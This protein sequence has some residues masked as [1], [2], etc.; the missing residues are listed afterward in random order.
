MFKTIAIKEWR[1]AW[2]NRTIV[3]G[4]LCL[5]LLLGIAFAGT[6]REASQLRVQRAAATALFRSQWEGMKAGNPHDAAHFGTYLFKP[7]PVLSGFDNGVNAVSGYSMRVEAH[8][9]HLLAAGPVGPADNYL[10]FGGLTMATVLG[11]FFPL[12]IILFCYATYTQERE[13]GTLK[14]LLL[15][16]ADQRRLLAGKTGFNLLVCNGLLLLGLLL[17]LPLLF[18]GTGL[19]AAGTDYIRAG[20]LVL[21][22]GSY[23]SILVLLC[24][25]FSAKLKRGTQVL[26]LL[27]ACWLFG[28]VLAP[29]VA[30]AAGGMLY[31]LP[32]RQVLQQK[33]DEAEKFGIH[34]DDPRSKRQ[35]RLQ[36]EWLQRYGVKTLAALPVNFDAIQMQAAEDYMQRI[37]DAEMGK[38]DRLIRAQN[39]IADQVA[40]LDPYLAL[41]SLSM[42]ICGSDYRHH[43]SFFRAAQQYRNDFIR[44]LN[45]RMA[46][47]GSKTG[48][49]GWKT[50]AAFFKSMPVFR[51]QPPVLTAV[52]WEQR[53]AIVSLVL[54]LLFGVFL[55]RKISVDGIL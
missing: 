22:Y 21:V 27:L 12:F 10:R 42:A 51:Y 18:V 14:L 15:Q 2:R 11:L 34:G 35:E 40:F 38:V 44:Q 47:G 31:P 1:T 4:A 29:R 53:Y 39:K 5:L 48:D 19:R 28:N 33:I 9:Q 43:A 3:G 13:S 36:R 8:V 17:Y 24:V 52:L 6:Q 45:E 26:L 25:F 49:Y 50:E 41:R 16:G 55:L 23:T 37:Y 20:L 54:W 7:L 32:S 30:A 46:Y